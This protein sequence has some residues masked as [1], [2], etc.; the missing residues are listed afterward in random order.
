MHLN[1]NLVILSIQKAQKMDLEQRFLNFSMAI[2]LLVSFALEA[3]GIYPH[4]DKIF[5]YIKIKGTLEM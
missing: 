1:F 4:R 3:R 2:R 5:I